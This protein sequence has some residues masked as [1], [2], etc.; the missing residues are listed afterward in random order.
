MRLLALSGR[1][2]I[3]TE[4]TDSLP[5]HILQIMKSTYSWGLWKVPPGAPPSPRCSAQRN[6]L[7]QQE[8]RERMVDI[9]LS[10]ILQKQ[11]CKIYVNYIPYFLKKNSRP[12]INRLPLI[13]ASPPPLLSSSL[14]L[15]CSP[16]QVLL[17]SDPV[18]ETDLISGD[19]SHGN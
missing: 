9:L 10:F 7:V 15:L 17:E 14:F 11:K 1:S 4:M 19:S 8:T 13:I 18:T 16:C 12:S 5:F 3:R 2:I 6:N